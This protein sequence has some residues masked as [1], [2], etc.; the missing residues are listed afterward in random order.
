[1]PLT[2]ED[3]R[4][5][6]RLAREHWI[7]VECKIYA[8]ERAFRNERRVSIYL[9]R[10]TVV[11]AALT[12]L[13]TPAASTAPWLTVVSGVVT[14]IL[15]AFD[16][17]F[18]PEKN[19]QTYWQCRSDLDAVKNDLSTLAM[20]IARAQDMGADDPFVQIKARIVEIAR[21]PFD[22]DAQDRTRAGDAFG[23]TMIASVLLR[24]GEEPPADDESPAAIASDAPGM[25]VAFRPITSLE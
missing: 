22:V 23:R 2:D 24:I 17:A 16:Q 25:V 13:T 1:M 11:S 7:D 21:T 10:G 15:A 8:Y 18:G 19:A 9:K 14:A 4:D 12:A 5:F 3:K 20:G 6:L